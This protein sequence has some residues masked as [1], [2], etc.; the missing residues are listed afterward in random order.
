MPALTGGTL[1]ESE[2][3]EVQGL[4]PQQ[5]SVAVVV[6]SRDS[7]I[8][9]WDPLWTMFQMHWPD[10]PYP[11]YLVSNLSDYSRAGV[12]TIA[13]GPDRSWSD[14]L[15]AAL[16]R[17]RE[18]YVLLWIDDHFISRPVKAEEIVAAVD[19]FKSVDGNYLRLQSL[20]KPDAPFNRHFG[21]VRSG[22]LYRTA[23]VASVWKKSVLTE[24]LQ[25]GE[26]AWDFEMGGSIRSDKYDGF[27]S[28]WHDCFR[29]ENLLIK[30]RIWRSSQRHIERSLGRRLD[31]DRPIMSRAEQTVLTLRIIGNR[32][33]VR[34]PRRFARVLRSTSNSEKAK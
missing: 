14:T 31:L 16:R 11:L 21:V 22:S 23:T 25:P 5:K 24:L 6:A 20:P 19:A 29:I 27:Y 28:T 10:C 1:M 4:K 15:L 34:L 12:S 8:D 3:M 33:L 9:L 7:S 2:S 13:V 30:G 26:S 18:E 17:V 32:L